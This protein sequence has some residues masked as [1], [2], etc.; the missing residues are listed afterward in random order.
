MSSAKI[1]V[2]PPITSLLPLICFK[3]KSKASNAALCDTLKSSQAI[4]FQS[5]RIFTFVEF[6]EMLH[7]GFS[8]LATSN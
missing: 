2:T 7:V 1:T 6:L 8:F 5:L 4:N 3:I